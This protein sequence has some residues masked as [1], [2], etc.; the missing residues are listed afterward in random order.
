MRRLK[1]GQGPAAGCGLAFRNFTHVPSLWTDQPLGL[2]NKPAS[3]LQ[4]AGLTAVRKDEEYHVY[5]RAAIDRDTETALCYKRN[6]IAKAV[7]LQE[8]CNLSSGL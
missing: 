6:A 3:R 8:D 5:K 7:A 1:R 4:T 2:T